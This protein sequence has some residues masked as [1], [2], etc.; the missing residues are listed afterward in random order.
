MKNVLVSTS[1]NMQQQEKFCREFMKLIS[2]SRLYALLYRIV[3]IIE[4]QLNK[5]LE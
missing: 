5:K 4:V 1:S 3:K 2:C